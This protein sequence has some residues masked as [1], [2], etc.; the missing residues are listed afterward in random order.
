[1][2]SAINNELSL[3]EKLKYAVKR[4]NGITVETDLRPY[5]GYLRRIKDI[6]YSVHGDKD[7]RSLGI[8]FRK[9]ATAGRNP[10]D[11]LCEVFTLVREACI[12]TLHI[13][14]F[15]VQIIAGIVMHQG[16]LAQM[17]TGEG[18]TMAAV[19]TACLNALRGHGV[20]IF[21]AND[22]LARRDA[23]WM[24]KIYSF[25]G[26]GVAWID[27]KTND[28]GRRDA[29]DADITY[30][31]ARQAGFDFLKDSIRYDRKG[32]LQREFHMALVD[33]ADFI[34]IDEAR[35]PMVIAMKKD[36]PEYDPAQIDSVVRSLKP[37][38][39][40]TIDGRFRVCALSA[41]GE[42]RV[43]N[44]IGCGGMHEEEYADT[45]GAIHASLHAHHL[46]RKDVDY[47]VKGAAVELVDE[48]TGRVADRRRWPYGIQTALEAKEGL[49]INP[50]GS[51]R[52]S[53][54]VQN[55]IKLYPKVAAMTA[56]AV[57]G[58]EE[59]I[60][61][62]GLPTV[63][64]PPNR[65]I[66][67]VNAP[68]KVFDDRTK[69]MEAVLKETAAAH[70]VGRPV[71]IGT[72]SIRESE[73]LA[74]L[75]VEHELP[76]SVLNAKDDAIEAEIVARAGRRGAVTIST[77]MAG[78]GTDIKL[79][80]ESGTDREELLELGGLYVIGT[81]KHESVRIDNQLR[82]RAGRQ[83]D[84][85]RS[86]F[87]ISLTDELMVRYG[88]R[89]FLP[90]M[91]RDAGSGEVDGE[92]RD[93]RVGKEI[94]RAQRI[95]ERQYSEMR[96][97]LRRYSLITETQRKHLL[98]LRRRALLNNELPEELENLLAKAGNTEVE[99]TRAL[100]KSGFVEGDNPRTF[101]CQ[102]F[103]RELDEFWARQL[104]LIDDLREGIHL[105][106][107]AGL[108]PLQ[109]FIKESD[110]AY[111][112]GLRRVYL[113]TAEAFSGVE[114]GIS[115]R[116]G[117]ADPSL[118]TGNTWTYLVNDNPFPS[119]TL[120]VLGHNNIASALASGLLLL[121]ASIGSLF[122]AL[123]GSKWR[124]PPF[125]GEGGFFRLRNRRRG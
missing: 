35:I 3:G 23:E 75:F 125:P 66:N 124:C 114:A 116:S 112:D 44:L 87:F 9:E 38:V 69:K 84:P 39:D 45:Y 90:K 15:D 12:R 26:L 109:V 119:F 73:E 21:T 14:P 13:K 5:E 10:D 94:D 43:Q 54:T 91:F 102:K 86:C 52:C 25:L 93:S 74:R 19:F 108:D 32:M 56:T 22:Y 2:K 62:Y 57:S 6:D 48:F 27:E 72:A 82:G 55:F 51:I 37:G 113:K 111:D 42:T 71:L 98:N 92:I 7:L 83:G 33:E 99:Q 79:G 68:D 50:E 85:G 28:E 107:Y 17:R 67:L 63:I 8:K 40:F 80:G 115:I 103:I 46:L 29:Y 18:K 117:F 58:A 65:Q 41:S 110:N 78:R 100:R 77:N 118:D 123:G 81:A 64:I 104:L 47:V 70:A 34:M 61:C 101:A 121:G 49:R 24:G 96:S 59:F 122:T 53:I 31:T 105:Q 120:S 4:G 11:L 76:C 88:V 1:M 106:R 16:K 95:I 60:T 36:R 97:T 20:H 89:E 30:L